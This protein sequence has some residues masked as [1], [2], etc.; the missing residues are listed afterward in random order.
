MS[1][2]NSPASPPDASWTAPRDE[3][4]SPNQTGATHHAPRVLA[5]LGLLMAF[6]SIS[7]DLYLP[8]MPEM[9][10]SLHASTGAV[11][12]T[13]SGY[14]IGFSLGQLLW[15][16]VSD[17]R[18]RRLPIAIGLLLFIAGSA[19]CA[20]ASTA[21]MLVSFRAIQAVGACAS[22]VLA[23]AMVRDLYTGARAAQMMSTLMTVMAIAPLIGPSVGGLIV[24]VASWRAVFWT[25]VGVGLVTL[26]LLRTLPETLPPT[27]RNS[28][29]LWRALATY[30]SLVGHKRLLGYAGAGGCFY[31]AT[32]AY[33]AGSPFAYM[34]YHHVS[35]EL[36]GVLFGAGI[37]GIMLVNQLNARLLSRFS[38]DRLMQA[39][40]LVA[41]IA[42]LVLALN[43]WRDW[44]GVAGLA[45]PLFVMVSTTG[46]IVANSIAGA[47]SLFP[48]IAGSVSALIGA[49]QY[50]TGI[51][52]SALVASFADG[53]PSSMGTVIAVMNICAALSALI[54]VRPN[55]LDQHN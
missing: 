32:F 9:A 10:I 54:L 46:M 53:T 42:G 19:G 48:E 1:T 17:R 27:R 20:L 21:S 24:R 31:G 40:T 13:I 36:Y 50:G 28:E 4:A 16:P 11:E 49:V 7:T 44:G 5:V 38:G 41:A 6:A 3:A 33:I 2:N 23:R 37:V 14:L 52:G 25:L 55:P 43:A 8:A 51:L 30:A 26:A 34:N 15:G 12:L 29:P 47:L 22:V 18:G 39:A 35:P 45:V